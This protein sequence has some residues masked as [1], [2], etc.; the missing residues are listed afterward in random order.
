M[1]PKRADGAPAKHLGD[2]MTRSAG[3]ILGERTRREETVRYDF[4]IRLWRRGL[5]EGTHDVERNM[6]TPGNAPVE[7]DREQSRRAAQFDIA[8]LAQLAHECARQGFVDFDA[9]ARQMPAGDIAVLDQEHAALRIDH[10]GAHADGQSACKAP[11]QMQKA[12]DGRF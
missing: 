12:P 8:L 4:T 5:L 6:I 1:S 9:A 2:A 10:Q 7:I 3:R 11:M